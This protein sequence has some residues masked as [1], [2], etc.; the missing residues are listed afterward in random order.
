MAADAPA[1]RG[2]HAMPRLDRRVARVHQQETARAVGIL[3]H[4]GRKAG[5]A[6]GG[7]LLVAGHRGD[8]HGAAK[9]LVARLAVDLAR[10]AHLR[11]HGPGHPQDPQQFVVPIQGVDIVEQRAAGV[12]VVGRVDTAAGQ[13]PEQPGIDRAEE[14]LAPLGAAAEAVVGVQQVRDLGAGEVGVDHQARLGP[15]GLFQAL[16]LQTIADAGTDAALPDDGR[17]DGPAG[18][19]VPEDRRLALVGH[20]HRRQI[21]GRQRCP[22]QGRAGR[23]QLRRPDRLG[24]VFHDARGR[25]DLRK[26]LLG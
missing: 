5:L 26:L 9:P 17:G 3:G 22:G 6:E 16:G 19:P 25:Q 8:G 21:A 20:A 11:Q 1:D 14:H 12:A 23:F 18:L 2:Q 10:P 15:K 7:R 24:V 13:A 4:A